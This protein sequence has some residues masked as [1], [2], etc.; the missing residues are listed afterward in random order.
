M[1]S[2]TFPVRAEGNVDT[3]PWLGYLNVLAG[4]W[5][6]SYSLAGWLYLPADMVTDT[7]SWTYILK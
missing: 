4:D 6:W 3:G 7:G 2:P 5:V 1:V